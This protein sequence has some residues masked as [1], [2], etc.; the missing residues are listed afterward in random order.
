MRF[1]IPS[2]YNSGILKWNVTVN[3]DSAGFVR[4]ENNHDV[5]VGGAQYKFKMNDGCYTIIK[6]EKTV[7][8]EFCANLDTNE[9]TWGFVNS[10]KSRLFNLES[11]ND[12]NLLTK[13]GG[14]DIFA[15]ETCAADS[16]INPG[17]RYTLYD[18]EDPAYLRNLPGD[19]ANVCGYE[20]GTESPGSATADTTN[21]YY[22]VTSH[23]MP[24]IDGTN[25]VFRVK[26]D[27]G[28]PTMS[29]VKDSNGNSIP[30]KYYELRAKLDPKYLDGGIV[31]W[32]WHVENT[33]TTDDINKNLL[34]LRGQVIVTTDLYG[35]SFNAHQNRVFTCDSLDLSIPQG[36]C[37]VFEA[38]FDAS[39]R[40]TLSVKLVD[41][42]YA[43]DKGTRTFMP[44]QDNNI[45]SWI[46]KDLEY[47]E[48]NIS[49]GVVAYADE[50]MVIDGTTYVF[51]ARRSVINYP[52]ED[53]YM[54]TPRIFIDK[55]YYGE[56]S[57]ASIVSWELWV[58]NDR[59]DRPLHIDTPY[60]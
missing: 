22:F 31:K 8:Y 27:P 52:N 23:V 44:K 39:S 20:R 59:T 42:Y 34:N 37:Y 36:W 43:R 18:P 48:D 46:P 3:N 28:N 17:G 5:T 26:Y 60:W 32:Q 19:L 57:C 38:T 4:L 16:T 47:N 33:S 40:R 58:K 13:N 25:K 41:K 53:R 51:R 9:F 56:R 24:L 30:C 21:A 49:E 29:C 2:K 45:V 55:K 11:G 7:T 10:Y 50:P 15:A 14:S 6:G 1:S 12:K 35:L 54:F